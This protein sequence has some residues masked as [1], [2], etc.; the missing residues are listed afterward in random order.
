MRAPPMSPAL[1][2][3]AVAAAVL[4][5]VALAVGVVSGLTTPIDHAVIH[6]VRDPDLAWWLSPLRAVTEL[7]STQ[8]VAA[9]GLV[10]F[11]V[12][13]LIGPWRHGVAA[14][15]TV[16]LASLL[17][18]GL[19]SFIARER[20]DLLE[21]LVDERGF[22]FPSGHAALSTVAYGVLAIVIARS[23]LPRPVRLGFAVAAVVL[24]LLIGL[25]RVW[26]GAH[27]P[28]DVLA[29]WISGA[30]VVTGYAWLTRGVREDP[31]PVAV[32]ADPP[33]V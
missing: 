4:T 19:K 14:A 10:A 13:M 2:T 31:S 18:A 30:V 27:Y 9:I 3:V 24:V 6:A 29:G 17:N 8:A 33:P 21:P 20:P 1:P 22:S 25:S 26:L 32:D 15:F 5:V 28:T 7:G 11:A 16:A 23:R 12:A